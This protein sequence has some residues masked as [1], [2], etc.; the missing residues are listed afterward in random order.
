MD[1][2]LVDTDILIDYSKG[3]SGL[4]Q[5]LFELQKKQKVELFINPVI[6]AEYFTDQNLAIKSKFNK[7]VKFLEFFRMVNI[8]KEIGIL[9]GRLSREKMVSYLGDSL[10]AATC[11][12]GKLK[13]ATRNKKH[14][15]NV[16][17]L[18]FYN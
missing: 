15:K 11:L 2:V 9:A 18:N 16:K 13:L 5:K 7:A 6:T 12:Q 4:L 14:F 3:F 10:I 8:N 1:K 17:D